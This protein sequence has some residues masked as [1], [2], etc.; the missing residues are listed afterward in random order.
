MKVSTF[1][2]NVID[3]LFN[4]GLE[5]LSSWGYPSPL[6]IVLFSNMNGRDCVRAPT[7]LEGWTHITP[8]QFHLHHVLS[9]SLDC[10]LE[11]Q[12]PLGSNDQRRS[13]H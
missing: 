8:V 12:Y 9:N 3:V 13:L 5:H 11:R 7:I 2:R 10:V 4:S 1:D 6:G